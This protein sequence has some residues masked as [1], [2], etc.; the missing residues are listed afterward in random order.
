M[1][2]VAV[3]IYDSVVS[4]M[5]LHPTAW[6]LG[7]AYVFVAGVNAMPEP[8]VDAP[9][10][11]S[12]YRWLYDFLHVLSNHAAKKYPQLDQTS[13]TTTTTTSNPPPK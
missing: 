13:T 10:M 8:G 6:A 11:R 7:V 1:L 2:Q 9:P 3:T 5:V 4:S 12:A